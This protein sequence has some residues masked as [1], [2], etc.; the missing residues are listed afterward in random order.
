[1]ILAPSVRGCSVACKITYNGHVLDGRA[2][3]DFMSERQHTNTNKKLTEMHVSPGQ[4][5]SQKPYSSI[6]GLPKK[7][8]PLS[9]L[10]EGQVRLL[11][12]QDEL[13]EALSLSFKYTTN[14]NRTCSIFYCNYFR[15]E[16]VFETWEV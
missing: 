6:V 12:Q 10:R 9:V 3:Y 13:N 8:R 4:C 2:I 5:D 7:E 14:N 1:L 16:K 15:M 11:H